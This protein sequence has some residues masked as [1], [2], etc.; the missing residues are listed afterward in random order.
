MIDIAYRRLNLDFVRYFKNRKRDKVKLSEEKL[1]KVKFEKNKEVFSNEKVQSKSEELNNTVSNDNSKNKK[2]KSN[3]ENLV[4]NKVV[5]VNNDSSN[6]N[7]EIDK[8]DKKP[9]KKKENTLKDEKKETLDTSMLLKK[10]SDRKKIQQYVKSLYYN[11]G[12]SGY[13]IGALIFIGFV[14][15]EENRINNYNFKVNGI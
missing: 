6:K 4:R 8:I 3:V 7:S 10:K 1:K 11:W 15:G 5:I 12:I 2:E 13:G 9:N 14:L